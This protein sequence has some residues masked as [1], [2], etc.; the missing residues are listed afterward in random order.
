MNRRKIWALSVLLAG[1]LVWGWVT[2]FSHRYLPDRARSYRLPGGAGLIALE[3]TESNCVVRLVRFDANAVQEINV[4]QLVD[5]E[6]LGI[7]KAGTVLTRKSPNAWSTS[8]QREIK[9]SE[10]KL[11]P[12]FSLVG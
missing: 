9:L 1:L 12:M 2:F 5:S 8:L 3:E 6:L 10:W 7:T 4:P 11:N